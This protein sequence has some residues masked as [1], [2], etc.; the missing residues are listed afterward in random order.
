MK[1]H[2][3]FLIE[4]ELD[5]IWVGHQHVL[6]IKLGKDKFILSDGTTSIKAKGHQ[7]VKLTK[8]LHDKAGIDKFWR[9][10]KPLNPVYA[11]KTRIVVATPAV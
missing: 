2:Y 6:V 4:K 5:R 8:R 3:V 11:P 9:A 10:M 7:I 1:N